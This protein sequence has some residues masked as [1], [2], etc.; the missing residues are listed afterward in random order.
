MGVLDGKTAVVTGAGRAIGRAIALA[1]VREG[2]NVIAAGRTRETLE[3]TARLAEGPGEIR[4]IIADVSDPA[5]VE[6][7]IAAAT[8]GFGRLDTL[9]NNAAILI[10][11][12]VIDS[13]LEEY[14]QTMAI[15][16][17]GV[18]VACKLALPLIIES[19]GGSIINNA[20]INT[21][22]AEPQL[23]L[24]AASKGA[25]LMLSKSIAL[26]HATQGI[27]CNAVCPGFV[28]TPLNE[29]HYNKLGGREALEAGLPS[30]QPIGRPIRE[31][32]IAEPVVFLASDASTAITGT[33][34][35]VDGGVTAKA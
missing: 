8:A 15:N 17:R 24:Y 4:P 5:D 34:F 33:T 22:V 35:I 9:V 25:V 10:P 27:R 20:T 6:A 16:V 31:D 23:A 3:E 1:F 14:E 7:M 18:Y 2:A 11:N 29:P 30:F 32:E 26:D 28:D 12:T 21:V 13:T 19:G